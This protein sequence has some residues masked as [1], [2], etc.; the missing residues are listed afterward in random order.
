MEKAAVGYT[1]GGRTR[2]RQFGT[3]AAVSLIPKSSS[4]SSAAG[5]RT[6]HAWT[7][8]PRPQPKKQHPDRYSARA[9]FWGRKKY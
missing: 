1:E 6:V 9:I 3:P 7:T 8:A 5:G 4:S 2:G